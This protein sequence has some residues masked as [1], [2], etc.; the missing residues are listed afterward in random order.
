MKSYVD[1]ST[2]QEI[3]PSLYWLLKIT[4]ICGRI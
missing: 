2:E 3:L 1:V 4:S